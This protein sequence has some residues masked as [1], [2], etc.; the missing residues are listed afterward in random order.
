MSKNNSKSVIIIHIKLATE[1]LV[2]KVLKP[3]LATRINFVAKK[4]KQKI[5]TDTGLVVIL[6]KYQN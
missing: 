2:A 1:I 6:H 4:T 3:H 5:A